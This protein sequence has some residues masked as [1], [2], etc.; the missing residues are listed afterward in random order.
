[1]VECCVCQNFP[2]LR[3]HDSAYLVLATLEIQ[4]FP[5]TSYPTTNQ[6]C[7]EMTWEIVFEFSLIEFCKIMQ[8]ID[9]G[10]SYHL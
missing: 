3:V 10:V 5:W 1:M 9:S 7:S 8:A 6:S 4:L 2:F